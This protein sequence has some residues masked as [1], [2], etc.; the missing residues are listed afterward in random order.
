MAETDLNH[1]HSVQ[2]RAL[3]AQV[4]DL[5]QGRNWGAACLLVIL[6]LAFAAGMLGNNIL[7]GLF[8][9]TGVLG[10][11]GQIINGKITRSS[12]PG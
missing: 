9:G 10:V 3:D 1:S 12:N 5:K 6:G 11:I 7:A 2:A 4:D 8:L